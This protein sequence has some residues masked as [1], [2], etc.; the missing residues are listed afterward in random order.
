MADGRS[1]LA[2]LRAWVSE[3]QNESRNEAQTRLDLINRLI[4]ECFG[5]T[6]TKSLR[7]SVEVHQRDGYTDYELGRP[8]CAIWE[9]KR[10][11]VGF[12]LSPGTIKRPIQDL[13]SLLQRSAE[14]RQA[15]EQVQRYCASRGVDLAV[16]TNG[17][18]FIVFL[19]TRSDGLSPLEGHCFAIESLE[20]L[21]REFSGAWDLLSPDG[22]SEKRY[23]RVLL[24]GADRNI[25]PKLSSFL[26]EYPKHR[27]PSQVQSSL[28]TLAELL[29]QDIGGTKD[30]EY[31]FIDRCYCSSGALSQHALLN[32]RILEARY[33]AMTQASGVAATAEPINPKDGTKALPP[34]VLEEAL[35]RRPVILIG[36]VGV[37]KTSFLKNFIYKDARSVFENAVYIYLNLGVR[38]TLEPD[39]KE[40]LVRDT[41]VQLYERY[42]ID[43]REETFLRGVYASEISRFK[44]GPFRGL[45]SSAPEQ[46]ELR[47]AEMLDGFLRDA[48]EHLRRSVSHLS[49]GRH[50]QVIF[51]LDNADQRSDAVQQ[52][53]FLISQELAQDWNCHV[54]VALRPNTF[55]RSRV[56][57]V[58]AAYP[59]RVFTISPP[60]VDDFLEK[61]LT[62]A[63]DMAEGRL[64]LER[65][66]GI[67][68]NITSIAMV[69]RAL[70]QS[71]Q[72]NDDLQ[73]LLAN[74]TG[75]NVRELL[76]FVTSFI[77]SPNVDAEKIVRI[78]SERGS[79]RIPLHEF[80]KAALLGDYAHYHSESSLALNLFDVK[81]P[82]PREHFLAPLILAFL[83]FEGS[84]KQ[85]DGFCF[86]EA[87]VE[88]AQA[89]GFNSSQIIEALER[90]LG[91][92][93]I[94]TPERG[95]ALQGK[96]RPFSRE[97]LRVTARGAYHVRRWMPT[98]AYIDA[99]AF[100][101]PIFEETVRD[102]LLP[103]SESFSIVVRYARALSFRKY[104]LSQW[105]AAGIRVPYFDF[106]DALQRGEPSFH[107]VQ[108][109]LGRGE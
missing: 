2:A 7:I 36:D 55:Y 4:T 58:L 27:Y 14:T 85:A 42:S 61:R 49:K 89:C 17:Q 60:R 31:R 51:I 100:D 48:N 98:F 1:A 20:H 101:T 5:W 62:Y 43:I 77:G 25:P 108:S 73:E 52:E 91:R 92:K 97:T 30:E 76:E 39:I 24:H 95:D 105:H 107:S 70:L 6:N 37:G 54:F 74:I 23:I 45:F 21:E 35:S 69:I 93:L 86:S 26:R 57:G 75:G 87:I 29:L 34:E 106:N 81:Y 104:L 13:P 11:T 80:S 41:E 109:H 64:P 88:E 78:M 68:L 9:A 46:A 90:M 66:A 103:E 10:E 79:Y 44:S 19:A 3:H 33:S 16:L 47:L 67:Q 63:L 8:R 40:L 99:M 96:L 12:S 38:G 15:V 84:H 32:R 22:I 59:H 72:R 28:R 50:R 71:L 18:Q 56:S 53:V 83:D 65:I 82:D 102:A 94:E